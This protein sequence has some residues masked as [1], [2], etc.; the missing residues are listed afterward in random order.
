MSA[1]SN[2]KYLMGMLYHGDMSGLGFFHADLPEYIFAQG[3]PLTLRNAVSA[4]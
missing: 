3:F 2:P 4:I 1:E